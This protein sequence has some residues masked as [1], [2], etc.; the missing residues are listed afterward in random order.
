[1]LPDGAVQ[2]YLRDPGGNL[3]E[4]DTPDVGGLSASVAAS[5]RALAD[6]VPRRP[7]SAGA[8]LYRSTR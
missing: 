1:M 3:V 7:A 2:F 4:I 5:L 8:T 6:E